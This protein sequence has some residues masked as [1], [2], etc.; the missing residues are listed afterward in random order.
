M[1][2][3]TFRRSLRYR[4]LTCSIV[5]V[6][7]IGGIATSIIY[8]NK[9]LVKNNA[10]STSQTHKNQKEKVAV[11]ISEE[12]KKS[13]AEQKSLPANIRDDNGASNTRNTTNT[14]NENPRTSNTAIS[15][16]SAVHGTTTTIANSVP[17]NSASS[18][19]P[20]QASQQTP[21]TSHIAGAVPPSGYSGGIAL[22]TELTAKANSLLNLNKNTAYYNQFHAD[23]LNIALGKASAYDVNSGIKEKY[24]SVQGALY[25]SSGMAYTLD[26]ILVQQ[27]SVDS[28]DVNNIV[29]TAKS[30]GVLNMI[31]DPHIA[32]DQTYAEVFV[33]YTP[34]KTNTIY[35]IYDTVYPRPDLN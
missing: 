22:N 29:N 8:H 14:T 23:A 18:K 32:L 3:N 33:V 10:K 19:I 24:Y 4:V 34:Q 28:N 17:Q 11:P 1:V 16:N 20:K 13:L 5:G 26:N 15:S 35:L 2:I 12:M 31:L 7:V 9:I 30:K 6:M 21:Q 27:C 25:K